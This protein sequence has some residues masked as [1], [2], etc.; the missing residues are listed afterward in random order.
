MSI[1]NY[2]K[3]KKIIE[4]YVKKSATDNNYYMLADSKLQKAAMDSDDIFEICKG[5]DEYGSIPLDV[6]NYLIGIIED[7]NYWLLGHRTAVFGENNLYDNNILKDILTNGLINNGHTLTN[8]SA[9]QEVPY[10]SETANIIDQSLHL[11]IMLKSH[12]GDS[13]GMDSN[14]TVLLK[15][16]KEYMD[17]EGKI[18]VDPNLIYDYD[19]DKIP[20]IKSEFIIGVT[21]LCDE[22]YKGECKYYSKEEILEHQKQ[23]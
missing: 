7:E 9:K 16:P 17:D 12:R 10:I 18:L 15:I 19:E 13:F 11:E 22:Q 21:T 3:K 1:F 14:G 6:A 8:G 23:R 2:M 4:E 5:W 20:H